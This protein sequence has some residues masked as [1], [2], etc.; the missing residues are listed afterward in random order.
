MGA[1]LWTLGVALLPLQMLVALQWPGG[2]SLTR[3]AMSDLGVTVCG[4]FAD[5]D[6]LI[7]NVC[8]PWHAVFNAGLIATGASTAM[9]AALLYGWWNGVSGRVGVLLVGVSG[10]FVMAVGI[11][12]WDVLPDLHDAAALAQAITQW[13][14]MLLLATAAGT[15]W[16]RLLTLA[17]IALSIASFGAFLSALEGA[18]V[19]FLPFGVA[20]RLAFDTLTVWTAATGIV[21]LRSASITRDRRSLSPAR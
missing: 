11:A 5:G 8:S 17:T 7:R 12:P 13:C 21:V 19:S 1:V 4:L 9:G 2:Y 10:L 18:E 6:A 20:E 15:G 14:A 3:N 16:F